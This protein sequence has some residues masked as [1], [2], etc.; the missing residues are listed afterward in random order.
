MVANSEQIYCCSL[1]S[2]SPY[3]AIWEDHRVSL[4]SVQCVLNHVFISVFS[5]FALTSQY[6]FGN[7]SSVY[8]NHSKEQQVFNIFFMSSTSILKM[9]L[10][11]KVKKKK[12]EMI[13]CC[14]CGFSAGSLQELR[15]EG[16]ERKRVLPHNL[17]DCFSI[18]VGNIYKDWELHIL[19][20]MFAKYIGQ[21]ASVNPGLFYL[22]ALLT[23][24]L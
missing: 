7:F 6:N 2:C 23:A 24:F 18:I 13:I 16:C 14:C 19:I 5:I 11:K 17:L 1:Q 12:K 8:I 4:S 9:T 20:F 21:T 10:L 22:H 3:V 15:E